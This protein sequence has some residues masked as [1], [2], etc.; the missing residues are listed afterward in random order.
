[1]RGAIR[2]QRR[3]PGACDDGDD[4]LG[5][6]SDGIVALDTR[7]GVEGWSVA[8]GTTRWLAR[9]LSGGVAAGP[10]VV[11]RGANGSLGLIDGRTG[12]IDSVQQLPRFSYGWL[13]TAHDAVFASPEHAR[14]FS[15]DP[16]S[17]RTRWRRQAPV[18]GESFRT[19]GGDGVVVVGRQVY[20]ARSGRELWRAETA[21]AALGAGVALVERPRSVEALDIRTGRPRWTVP[22]TGADRRIVAGDGA[23]ALITRDRLTA[24][25]ASS[26]ATRWSQ[27]LEGAGVRFYALA[28]IANGLV[29]VTSTSDDW[30]P[31]DE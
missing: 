16:A 29:L 24:L 20:D 1:V 12:A 28:T 13:V 27:P 15:I 31:Y 30:V 2:W 23:V 17:G 9:G 19:L 11:A 7:R 14:L 10:D 6:P 25:D 22:L 18:P 8:S 5:H 26:G 4:A 21:V 3:L